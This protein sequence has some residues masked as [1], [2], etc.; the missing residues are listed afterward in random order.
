ML[1]S[2]MMDAADVT[3]LS[4]RFRVSASQDLVAYVPFIL[5]LRPELDAERVDRKVSRFI[6]D[7]QCMLTAV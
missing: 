2:F 3:S 6:R 5:W 4:E 1:K 7:Y